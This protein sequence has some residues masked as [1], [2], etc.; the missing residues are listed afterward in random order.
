V[1]ARQQQRILEAEARLRGED[2]EP[3]DAPTVLISAMED[4]DG[5]LQRLKMQVSEGQVD[6]PALSAL[7]DWI[8]RVTRISKTIV[9]ARVDE[10]RVRVVEATWKPRGDHIAGVIQRV[11]DRCGFDYRPNDVR[12]FVMEE[13]RRD[14]APQPLAITAVG[15]PS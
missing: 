6:G 2:F 1:R 8:D 9:D 10:R 11:F 14:P 13:L 3:R 4:A 5:I 12:V 7:G 15:E